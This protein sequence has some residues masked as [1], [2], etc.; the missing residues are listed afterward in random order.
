MHGEDG[1]LEDSKTK[2]SR[3]GDVPVYSR[4]LDRELSS[5]Q[6]RNDDCLGYIR[7]YIAQL[8]WGLQ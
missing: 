5:K 2:M 7:D 4:L 1:I 8:Q 3:I 6:K